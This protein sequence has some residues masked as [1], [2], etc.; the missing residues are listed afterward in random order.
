[1][2][3]ARDC[4]SGDADGIQGFAA[5]VLEGLVARSRATAMAFRPDLVDALAQG[6]VTQDEAL[7]ERALTAFRRACITR[8]AMA[9]VYVPAAARQLGCHWETDA[10]GFAEVSIAS[11]RLQA[12]ARAIGA[13]RDGEPAA[14]PAAVSLL[15]VVPQGEDHTLGAVVAA[16]QLRR[17]GLSVCLRLCPAAGEVAE[18]VRTRSF[19]AVFLSLSCPEGIE[20]VR[21]LVASVR[22]LAG[23]D[24]PLVVGGAIVLRHDR[25][26]AATGADHATGD[27]L[28]ALRF[29]GLSARPGAP[30]TEPAC[31]SERL[32]A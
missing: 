28:E 17:L 29:C 11:A 16:G 30:P 19:D 26:V 1:M 32:R 5:R 23:A 15:L 2:K 4:A 31:R 9:D 7:I 6:M 3:D 13:Q 21:R 22:K 8:E 27:T 14:G 20:P 18:L 25:L 12:L 10:M 24:L